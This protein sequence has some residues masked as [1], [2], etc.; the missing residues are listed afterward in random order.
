MLDAGFA[1]FDFLIGEWDVENEFL[2]ERLAGCTEWE[3]F[4]ATSRATKVM[5]GHANLD[6]FFVPALNFTGMTLRLYDPKTRLWSIYWSDT[7]TCRLFPP[8]IG[9]FADGRGEFY[10]DDVEGGTSVK[11]RFIW[12]RGA[13]PRWEQS[14]S[15]DGGETWELNWVMK[16][17]R[18]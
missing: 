1:D 13:S 7:R 15:G 14:M 18:K 17:T 11:I 16:F 6:Q 8:T 9:K 10:G 2:K 12:T 5:D 4:A 3:R